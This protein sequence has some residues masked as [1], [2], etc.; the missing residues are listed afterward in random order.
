MTKTNLFEPR[1]Q[2][3]DMARM[4]LEDL[5][6]PHGPECP[7]CGSGDDQKRLKG[8]KHRSG[9][10][11]C[12][13][14]RKQYTVT[15]GT[16]FERSKVPLNK[17]LLATHLMCAS[18]KGVSAH[19]LHRMLG[20]TYKTAW[21]MAHRIREAMKTDGGPM[22]G[23]G[24]DVEADETYYGKRPGEEKNRLGMLRKNRIVSLVDRA[25][26]RSTSVVFNGTFNADTIGQY[27]FT[28]VDRSSRLLT[29]EHQAYKRPGLE[30]AKHVHVAHARD[31]WV[32]EH[33]RTAHTNT[34]EGFFGIFKRGMRGIYQHCGQ[35]HLHRYLAEFDFRYSNRSGRGIED[36]ERADIALKGIAGKRLTYRR[37][38]AGTPAAA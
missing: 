28:N 3:A 26:G 30:F 25:T 22:G 15:V 17:W 37:I 2:D 7:H 38:G 21:F 14:C 1:F 13:N 23:P 5:R 8:D 19:Q 33:D 32:S 6:W 24:S 16:V 27:L 10:V 31:E 20:V 18:K 11:Q 34:V 29:D 36:R 12:N 4:Y 35:Q 9:V